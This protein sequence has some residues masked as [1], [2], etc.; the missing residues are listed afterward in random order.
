MRH[1]RGFTLI[2][3][4]VV[5]AIIA[6]L[7]SLAIPQYLSYQRK[8]KVSSY[9]E[10]IARGCIMDLAAFCMENPGANIQTVVGQGSPAANCRGTTGNNQN[11]NQNQNQVTF[12][13]AG[14][15]VTL[16]ANGTPK[17]NADG[18]LTFGAAND[19][20]GIVATLAGVNDYRARCFAEQGTSSIRC[21]I[22]AQ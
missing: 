16:S 2:E 15:T 18:T 21:T 6:I 12:S 4:L 20:N 19:N 13:T 1:E 22:E 8:A 7:A 17:C 11:Q 9:A 3:L 14:G 10:P 5:I